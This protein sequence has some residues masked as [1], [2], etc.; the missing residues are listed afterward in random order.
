MSQSNEHDFYARYLNP[1]AGGDERGDSEPVEDQRPDR[2]GEGDGGRT[3]G[4][5]HAAPER[6]LNDSDRDQNGHHAADSDDDYPLLTS[7]PGQQYPAQDQPAHEPPP[8][9]LD[10]DRDRE[11]PP[12]DRGEPPHQDR[13]YPPTDRWEPSHPEPSSPGR[14]EPPPSPPRPDWER[15]YPPMDR[16]G[17]QPP[18]QYPPYPP[19]HYPPMDRQGDEPPPLY[20]PRQTPPD[21]GSSPHGDGPADIH[22]LAGRHRDSA[23]RSRPSASVGQMRAQVRQADLVRPYKPVPEIGWRK[24]LHQL[25]R[26]NPGVGP[27]EREWIDL[28][29]RLGVNLRGTYL[30]AIMQQKGGASK[31]TSTIGLGEALAR[32]R[33]DKVVAI[34]ANPANGNLASRVDEPSTGTWRSLI[35]DPHL[36][37][38]SDFR[39]YLGK[40]SSSGLEV[41]GSDIGDDVMTGMNLIQ[42][43]DKLSRQYPI[44]LIDCGNQMRDDLTAAILS[45]VDAVVVV[46]T[47]RYDGAAGAQDTLNW[48]ISHGYPHLVRSAVMLISNVNKVSADRAVR[49]LH[50]DFERVCRAVHDI[51]YDPHLSDATAINFDRLA[52]ATRRA[53]L[54]AA[55]SVVDGFAGAADKDSGYRS[56][57]NRNNQRGD[58]R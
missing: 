51:P 50:E 44:G 8:L 49:N 7:L 33:D 11:Y 56:G 23:A 26:I 41:L 38:Y 28:K 12:A 5:A 40:D 48:L 6:D 27:A 55:A 42:A 43:W 19:Q 32:Y 13:R 21:A 39:H 2:S 25:T 1:A 31:T 52:P 15:Q 53:Y 36:V 54:E 17:E 46:S 29:R 9:D 35:A 58:W 34:D 57:S 22:D 24:K 14:Q 45:R 10:R 18:R 4:G 20:P 16:R 30:I 47:T 3:G 37:S